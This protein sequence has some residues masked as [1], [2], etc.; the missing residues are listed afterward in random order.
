MI[1]KKYIIYAVAATVA[2]ILLWYVPTHVFSF[3]GNRIKTVTLGKQ[4]FQAE[5][6]SSDEKLQKGLGGRS[7][8]CQSCAMLF[9][10]SLFG[11]YSFW[12]KDMRFPLDIVWISDGRINH[13]EKNVPADFSSIFTPSVDADK[14]L[15]LNV[16]TVDRL[17]AKEGDAVKL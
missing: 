11:R 5:V 10:F 15:E 7:S 9:R 8:L 12:M 4:K 13:I 3:Y 14:V 2:I 17:G 16:G 1:Y 6:V